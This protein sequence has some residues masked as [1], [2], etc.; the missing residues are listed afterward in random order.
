[1]PNANSVNAMRRILFT[2]VLLLAGLGLAGCTG[3]MSGSFDE[4]V[5]SPASPPM[6]GPITDSESGGDLQSG[7]EQI[8]VTGNV[9]ITVESPIAAADETAR[10]VDQA[11]GHIASR[12]ERAPDDRAPGSARL[13]VRIPTAELTPTLDD[14]KALGEANETSLDETN[15]SS[16]LKDLDARIAALQASVDRLIV[17]MAGADTTADLITIEQALSERQANLESLQAQK[18]SLDD[19]VQLSTITIYFISEKD[20][21]VQ[22]PETFLSGLIAG[23]NAFVGFWAT[24]LVFVG[25]AA[26]WL[27]FVGL[28]AAIVL[29]V[30]RRSIRKTSS[31]AP[32]PTTPASTDAS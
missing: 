19:Q 4:G 21:P 14:I 18:R 26:P 13:V 6:Q 29:W 5:V 3:S 2:S 11:G 16:Q 28:V 22:Q 23:W 10:I 31:Q 9:S 20:A 7:G 25:V 1:M 12:T 24:M 27:I 30:V 17:L 8:I 15:V 32:P